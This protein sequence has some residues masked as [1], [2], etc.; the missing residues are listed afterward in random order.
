[1]MSLWYAFPWMK[2]KAGKPSAKELRRR[3]SKGGKAG[4]GQAK[5]RSSEQARAAAN[6]RWGKKPRDTDPAPDV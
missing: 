1:M 5:A 4:T 6:V 3:A 2:K